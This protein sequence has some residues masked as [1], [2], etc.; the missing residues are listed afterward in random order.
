MSLFD[1]MPPAANAVGHVPRLSDL[2]EGEET[3]G[4]ESEL[5]GRRVKVSTELPADRNRR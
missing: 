2:F 3:K 4:R 1:T 5:L